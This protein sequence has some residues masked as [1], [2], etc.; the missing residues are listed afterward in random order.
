MLI[1]EIKDE[2]IGMPQ[3][4]IKNLFSENAQ[5]NRI[6]TKNETGTGFGM[7]LAK[8][9]INE[10]GAEIEIISQEKVNKTDDHGST[11]LIKF[12]K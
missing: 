11:F 5:T 3:E 10:Y 4:I 12:K 9:F 8:Y 7:P 6:G 1:I 2:G